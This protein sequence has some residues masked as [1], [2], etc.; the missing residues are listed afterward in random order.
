MTDTKPVTT[1]EYFGGCPECGD[2]DAGFN[3]GRSH[4]SVCTTHKT[5]WGIGANL[6]SSWHD[7]TEADWDANRAK[8]ADYRMVKPVHAPV[9]SCEG[10]G[11]P[12]EHYR[13]NVEAHHHPL[14]GAPIDDES[15]RKVL[16]YLETEELNVTR[17]S[18]DDVSL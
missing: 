8:Y 11:G 17:C 10:C 18:L 12:I 5:V 13:D 3:I 2:A 7:E 16:S 1:N 9:T 15:I 4:Y 6:F 14:C